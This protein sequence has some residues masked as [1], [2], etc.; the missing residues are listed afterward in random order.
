MWCF[1]RWKTL[2]VHDWLVRIQ[3]HQCE[4]FTE[5]KWYQCRSCLCYYC[6]LYPEL[7]YNASWYMEA[8]Q[9]QLL[10]EQEKLRKLSLIYHK[11]RN[12]FSRLQWLDIHMHSGGFSL[13]PTLYI[14]HLCHCSSAQALQLHIRSIITLIQYFFSSQSL[15]Y[16]KSVTSSQSKVWGISWNTRA[17]ETVHKICKQIHKPAKFFGS[18]TG[19]A[20]FLQVSGH[21]LWVF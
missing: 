1:F 15:E 13:N 3:Q 14:V 4:Y 18:C 2:I 10:Y 7:A 21:H 17:G 8:P 6:A 12:C 19:W 20:V 16:F 5:K 11:L 9:E